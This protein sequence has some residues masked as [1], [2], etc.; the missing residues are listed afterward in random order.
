M[1]KNLKEFE[2]LD[3]IKKSK[4]IDKYLENKKLIKTIY[5]KDRL[6]NYITK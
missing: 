6:L 1:Q 3:K 5:V 4:K 2:I